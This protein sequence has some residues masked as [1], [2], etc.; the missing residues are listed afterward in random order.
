MARSRRTWIVALLVALV[1][2]CGCV[3]TVALVWGAA[4]QSASQGQDERGLA[5]RAMR[6]VAQFGDWLTRPRVPRRFIARVQHGIERLLD[7]WRPPPERDPM[8]PSE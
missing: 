7:R 1:M 3:T 8:A 5:Q 2:S 6:G 4:D